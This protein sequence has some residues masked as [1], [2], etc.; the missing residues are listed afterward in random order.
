VY[1]HVNG[2]ELKLVHK[3][4]AVLQKEFDSASAETKFVPWVQQQI[5]TSNQIANFEGATDNWRYPNIIPQTPKE[6]FSHQKK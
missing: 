2:K 3:D 6:F 5:L 4:A 1:E